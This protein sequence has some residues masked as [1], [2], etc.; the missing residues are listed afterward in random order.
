M[1][2]GA[3]GI[4]TVLFDGIGASVEAF[5]L[6]GYT[7]LQQVCK[8]YCTTSRQVVDDEGQIHYRGTNGGK[9]RTAVCISC[10]GIFLIWA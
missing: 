5:S 4:T 2:C 6:N 7:A 10:A 3:A 9:G 1:L 8:M